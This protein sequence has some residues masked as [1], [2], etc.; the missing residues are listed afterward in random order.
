[1]SVVAIIV[2][3]VLLVTLEVAVVVEVVVSRDVGVVLVI[4]VVGMK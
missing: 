2:D 4:L 1:M 3:T